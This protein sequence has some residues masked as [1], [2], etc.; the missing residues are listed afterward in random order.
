MKHAPLSS[1]LAAE[2]AG[3]WFA[4]LLRWLSQTKPPG[5]SRAYAS[6]SYFGERFLLLGFR[7]LPVPTR[8]APCPRARHN[9]VEAAGFAIPGR[10][11]ST[12]ARDQNPATICAGQLGWNPRDA[13]PHQPFRRD[14]GR[15]RLMIL[16][17]MSII[18]HRN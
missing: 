15:R 14:Y 4:A 7:M 5:V 17:V 1:G 6:T 2:D 8:V 12:L 3:G 11:I 10:P 18:R 9:R 16:A 13:A